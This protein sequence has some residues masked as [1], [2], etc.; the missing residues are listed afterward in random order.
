MLG[1][2]AR[3]SQSIVAVVSFDD[4]MKLACERF[5]PLLYFKGL[6]ALTELLLS[7]DGRIKEFQSAIQGGLD[8]LSDAVYEVLNLTFFHAEEGE[9]SPD[10]F[11]Y[12]H[13]TVSDVRVVGIG[14]HEAT[15]T[16][17]A[18]LVVKYDLKWAVQDEDGE[19]HYYSNVEE[20]ISVTGSA[21]IFF[22]ASIQSVTTVGHVEMDDTEIELRQTPSFPR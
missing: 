3:K 10:N 1:A 6:P 15:V 7:S 22:D 8:K 17:E 14:D 20:D 11:E 5:P 18:E 4:D 13:P 2:Y 16:F 19:E 12:G 21:K 9:Y